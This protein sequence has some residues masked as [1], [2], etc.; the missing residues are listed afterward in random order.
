MRVAF[1]GLGVMGYPMAGYLAKAGHDTIV[2]NRTVAK[3]ERWVAEFGGASAATPQAAAV[4]AE[5]VF[6][7]VGNDDDVREVILGDDGIL[8]GFG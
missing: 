8:A 2:Y 7:C 6:V 4:D 5:I 3:A 1:I